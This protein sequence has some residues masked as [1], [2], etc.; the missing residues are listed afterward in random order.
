M[1]YY[2]FQ[3]VDHKFDDLETPGAK[4]ANNGNN[5]S[6]KGNKSRSPEKLHHHN[7]EK[8]DPEHVGLETDFE[9]STGEKQTYN[10]KFEKTRKATVS[11]NY[12][13]GY[14]IGGKANF[15]IG[16]PKVMP[17]GKVGTEIN[18]HV[19]VTKTTGE[20]FEETLTTC[21]T[22]DITVAPRSHYTATVVMEERTIRAA[23][24]VWVMMSMPA[25]ESRAFIKNKQGQ[26]IF[27]YKLRN[28]AELFP[29]ETHI[30]ENDKAAKHSKDKAESS[31][32]HL[33]DKDDSKDTHTK[34]EA[35]DTHTHTKDKEVKDAHTKDKEVKD[36][37]TKDTEV[38]DIHTKDKEDTHSEAKDSHARDKK[39]KKSRKDAVMF[40]VEGV[41]D[42]AQL[43]SH[44]IRLTDHN[45]RVDTGVQTGH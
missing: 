26:T 24:K 27:F 13:K 11:V 25:K 42:G 2:H 38:K 45:A 43:A 4:G 6:P 10:F 21:A 20:T 8:T 40:V 33:K 15:S 22:S 41:V 5:T 3:E 16:L 18:M 14:S 35:K 36:V 17:D 31:D 12:Q 32:S 19:T 23:F 37:H 28:L 9:N 29:K 30:E 7:K 34:E 39:K 1:N 44:H